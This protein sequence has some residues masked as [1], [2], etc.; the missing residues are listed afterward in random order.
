[1]KWVKTLS[2]PEIGVLVQSLQAVV[3]KR[4]YIIFLSGT[5]G[6][7]KTAFIRHWLMALGVHEHVASPTYSIVQTY[8]IADEPLPHFDCYRLS[9][10]EML[11]DMGVEDYLSDNMLVEWAENGMDSLVKPDLTIDI[12]FSSD[13]DSSRV[14]T[15]ASYTSDITLN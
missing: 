6:A 2:E 3:V 4:P 8:T 9:G 12:A 7:G 13:D 15:I 11:Y 5:L 1:M 10:A 14:Y